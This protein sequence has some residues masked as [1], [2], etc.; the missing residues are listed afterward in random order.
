MRIISGEA[1]GRRLARF[2]GQKIRPASDKVRGAIFNIL[3]SAF[4]GR[5]VLDLFAGTGALGIEALSRGAEKVVFVESS[6]AALRVLH[7]NLTLCRCG[8]KGEVVKKSVEHGVKLLKKHGER[9]DHIFLDPP[10]GKGI[11]DK[12]LHMLSSGEMLKEGGIITLKHSDQELPLERY[13][14]LILTDQR[15]YGKTYVSFFKG[16]VS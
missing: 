9:F 4:E 15:K 1:R 7:E 11:V 12:S 10:Y 8:N 5:E 16:R 3:G 13:G 6:T 2:K 14:N